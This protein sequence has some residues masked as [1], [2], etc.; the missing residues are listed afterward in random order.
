M[1]VF[2]FHNTGEQTI[3]LDEE[4][5]VHAVRVLRLK[6]SDEVHLIDGMGGFFKGEIITAHSKKCEVRILQ[7]LEVYKRKYYKHIAIAPPKSIDRFEWF[8]EKVTEIGVDEITPLLTDRS[9]RKNLNTERLEK[10][11][12]STMKQCIQPFRPKLNALTRYSDFIA[13]HK[14]AYIAHLETGEEELLQKIY[15]PGSDCLIL[16]GPEGDFSPAEVQLAKQNGCVSISLG[17]SRL[18][19]ETAGVAACHT[20]TVMNND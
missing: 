1:K 4:E 12:T 18:R 10:I 14:N 5:S 7:Q 20:I 3:V 17:H 15:Q 2:Y 11:L 13:Q 9:E 16:I 19:V 6:E 8:L